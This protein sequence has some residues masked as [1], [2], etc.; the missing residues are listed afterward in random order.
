LFSRHLLSRTL[1]L[2]VPKSPYEFVTTVHPPSDYRLESVVLW[3]GKD[4]PA[5]I[6]MDPKLSLL[7]LNMRFLDGLFVLVGQMDT[8][9]CGI[10]LH[11]FESLMTRRLPLIRPD[12]YKGLVM[13]LLTK[14][15]CSPDCVNTCRGAFCFQS[16]AR[17]QHVKFPHHDKQVVKSERI[18][19]KPGAT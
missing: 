12:G 18:L 4:I 3:S 1:T 14:L 8:I 7:V 15:Y 19:R 10:F 9:I 11:C 2:S 5:G 13:I 6:H 16:A 17:L